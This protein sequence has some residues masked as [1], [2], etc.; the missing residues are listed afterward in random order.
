MMRSLARFGCLLIF[1]V[2][3]AGQLARAGEPSVAENC[4]R[5]IGYL[6]DFLIANDTG[7]ADNRKFRGEAVIA[8]AQERALRDAS[9]A[10]TDEACIE[11]IQTF[12]SAWRDGHLEV[13]P[14]DWTP[15][16]NASAG[17]GDAPT[18]SPERRSRIT[19]LSNKTALLTFPTFFASEAETIRTLMTENRQRLERTP[20]WI[21]DVR[22]NNGG[23]DDTYAP[24]T[25]A[26]IG[27]AVLMAGVEFLATPANVE[28]TAGVCEWWAPGDKGC[29]ES[30][31]RLVEAMRAA[32]PG[33][34]V[35]HPAL[36]DVVTKVEPEDKGRKRPTR[37]AVLTDRGCG[38]SCEQFLLAM[39]Q[40]WN[41]K[42]FGRRTAG[43][44]DYSNLRPHKL[45]SGKRLVLYAT[46]RSTRLPHLPVDAVGV[47]P[48][49]FLPLPAGAA[50]RERE[51]DR[52]RTLLEQ[53]R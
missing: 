45:P 6:P 51:I 9:S 14:A 39:Q 24:I 29:L 52:V 50:E 8:A 40:S 12:F 31:G 33:T 49:V 32:K 17:A 15:N 46:S 30:I 38:S 7:A 27:N 26:V 2:A 25:D 47:L 36:K 10:S 13:V 16:G 22:D 18:K 48:D 5:D 37:V 11:I 19:W 34:Y 20:H 41:V 1:A 53:P 21:I 23:S 4:K 3:A 42:L 44:L 35:P 43:A 28:G